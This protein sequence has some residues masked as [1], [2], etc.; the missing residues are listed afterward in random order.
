MTVVPH[1]LPNR[2]KNSD[3]HLTESCWTG[4]AQRPTQG[5][6][7]SC[8]RCRPWADL[9]DESR[10]SHEKDQNVWH[11]EKKNPK[12]SLEKDW[13]GLHTKDQGLSGTPK[14]IFPIFP[15]LYRLVMAASL[16]VH[17][18]S[19]TASLLAAAS[20]ASR[21]A[22]ATLAATKRPLKKPWPWLKWLEPVENN[23]TWIKHG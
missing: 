1:G 12:I 6:R 8:R 9:Q 20:L 10:N 11:P 23:K 7:R 15:N 21:T 19:T 16:V 5:L 18:D 14:T 13:K 2:L 4:T 17:K 22:F 3:A